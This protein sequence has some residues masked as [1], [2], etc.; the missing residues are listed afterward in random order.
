MAFNKEAVL[1][2]AASLVM[3]IYEP[4]ITSLFAQVHASFT[5]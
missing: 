2:E 5:I 4:G 1:A 3:N